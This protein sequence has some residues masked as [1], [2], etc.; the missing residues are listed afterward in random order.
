MNDLEDR[1]RTEL[2]E[3]ADALL[4]DEK[5]M[6]VPIHRGRDAEVALHPFEESQ[7]PAG[8]H[9]WRLAAV[10]ASILAITGLGYLA[11][12]LTNSGDE[13]LVQRPAVTPSSFGTWETIAEAPI[14]PRPYAMT[15]WTGS[16]AVFWAGSSLTRGFA[17]SDGAIYNPDT[18][19]WEAMVVPGWGHPGLSSVFFDGELYAL[20]KGGGTRF[21][22]IAG[23]WIDLP[24]TEGMY[25]ASTVATDEAVYG[26]GPVTITTVGQPDLAI[27]RYDPESDSWQYGP[28]FE[29]TDDQA[30]IVAGLA[31]LESTTVW[32]G[33]EIVVWHSTDGGIAFN[34]VTE[35]WR[36][37][38]HP[39]S[40][41]GLIHGSVA[42]EI[43]DGMAVLAEVE[44]SDGVAVDVAVLRDEDWQWHETGIDIPGFE[45]V[46]VAGAGEWIVA[47]TADQAPVVIHLP[48]GAWQRTGGPL[49]GIDAPNTAWT[50]DQLIV[51]GGVKA[52]AD[53]PNGARW[54]APR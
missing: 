35:S 42:V 12:G 26:L 21:D 28:V 2:V 49:S 39:Q 43:D 20:A 4:R 52:D 36:T 8:P 46:T 5:T 17:Y 11:I 3:L 45:S 10:A 33:T 9:W 41:S 13:V 1:L 29:G 18:D 34:P 54:T 48:S 23:Q 6:G 53:A 27:A 37:M 31:R 22:P 15:A 38:P 25:L 50:G 47:F 40:P 30:E 24:P 16:E 14:E 7:L 44:N 19:S 51:W 32:T